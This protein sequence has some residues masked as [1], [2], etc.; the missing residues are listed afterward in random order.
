[1]K[2]K[3]KVKIYYNLKNEKTNTKIYFWIWIKYT[4]YLFLKICVMN[5]KLSSIVEIIT[6]KYYVKIHVI[7]NYYLLSKHLILATR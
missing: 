6:E 1:M 2:V 7:I 3:F 5:N 4:G